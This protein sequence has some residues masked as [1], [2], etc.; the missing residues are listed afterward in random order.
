MQTVSNKKHI[1]EVDKIQNQAPRNI[2]G[3]MRTTPA[4]AACEIDADTE[5][6]DIQRNRALIKAVKRYHRT[7]EDK[8]NRQLVE[9]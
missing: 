4:V 2:C 5:P 7:E 8:P 6:L 1:K 9:I 3:A